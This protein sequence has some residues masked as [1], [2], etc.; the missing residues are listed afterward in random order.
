MCF[1][2]C[3]FGGLVGLLYLRLLTGVIC[4]VDDCCVMVVS[5][6]GLVLVFGYLWCVFVLSILLGFWFRVWFVLVFW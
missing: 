6:L 4:L 5:G 2:I 1:L 3:V